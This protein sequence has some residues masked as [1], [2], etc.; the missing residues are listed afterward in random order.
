MGRLQGLG[1]DVIEVGPDTV[2]PE[3]RPLVPVDVAYERRVLAEHFAGTFAHIRARSLIPLIERLRPDIVLCDEVDFGAMVAAECT[4]V[5]RSSVT[6]A[7]AGL[8]SGPAVV[9]DSLVELRHNFGLAGMPTL[10]MLAGNL[11][12]VPVPRSFRS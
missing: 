2:G 12:L 10:D 6:V 5:P 4:G 1:Y 8:L 9:G 7:A 3:R 11:P